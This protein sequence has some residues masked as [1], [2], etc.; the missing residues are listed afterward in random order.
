MRTQFTKSKW[1]RNL[2]E[3]GDNINVL[4]EAL[5]V[6]VILRPEVNKLPEM[7]GP[8]DGPVPREVVEVVHDDGHEEI[9]HEEGAEHEEGDEVDIGKVGSTTLLQPS[10]I[11]LK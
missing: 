11:R 4:D 6:W 5:G 8:E 3:Q 9:E 7:V 2:P 10:V 1:R